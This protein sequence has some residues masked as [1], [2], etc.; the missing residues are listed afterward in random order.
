MYQVSHNASRYFNNGG[1]SHLLIFEKSPI[2]LLTLGIYL[3][4]MSSFTK[5]VV[6][7]PYGV[8]KHASKASLHVRGDSSGAKS[9]FGSPG[10]PTDKGRWASSLAVLSDSWAADMCRGVAPSADAERTRGSA[11]R[12]TKRW[13]SFG[14]SKYA[15]KWR[16]VMSSQPERA[17][18]QA[19]WSSR[20]SAIL[21]SEKMF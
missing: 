19:P 11:P 7:S 12:Q 4:I 6:K 14:Q 10:N 1:Y 2:S 5:K 13:A 21:Q 8:R 18:K 9:G 20:Y 16:G 15:A 3:Q 17:S